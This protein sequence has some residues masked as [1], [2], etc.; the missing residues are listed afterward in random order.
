[1]THLTKTP[2]LDEFEGLPPLEEVDIRRVFAEDSDKL[3]SVDEAVLA[4]AGTMSE[5]TALS[6]QF[7]ELATAKPF[8]VVGGTMTLM[9]TPIDCFGND[10]SPGSRPTHPESSIPWCSSG[11]CGRFCTPTCPNRGFDPKDF[12]HKV[13]RKAVIILNTPVTQ[14]QVYIRA[15]YYGIRTIVATGAWV[16]LECASELAPHLYDLLAEDATHLERAML[17]IPPGRCTC[18]EHLL[19]DCT[20]DFQIA[21]RGVPATTRVQFMTRLCAAGRCS[22]SAGNVCDALREIAQNR[23]DVDHVRLAGLFV[24]QRTHLEARGLLLTDV[25]AYAQDQIA[26][27]VHFGAR[28]A[29]ASLK[30][31]AQLAVLGMLRSDSSYPELNSREFLASTW[32]SAGTCGETDWR[33][34]TGSPPID[35]QG[36][37]FLHTLPSLISGEIPLRA[38]HLKLAQTRICAE[39]DQIFEKTHNQADALSGRSVSW[40]CIPA[41][42]LLLQDLKT[43]GH[44]PRNPT[45]FNAFSGFGA[46][47]VAISTLQ[48]SKLVTLDANRGAK[49]PTEELL[50]QIEQNVKC[51][52]KHLVSS[53]EVGSLAHHG[54][55]DLTWAGP[56]YGDLE[57]YSIDGGQAPTDYPNPKAFQNFIRRMANQLASLTAVGGISVVDIQDVRTRSG[58]YDLTRDLYEAMTKTFELL[59]IYAKQPTHSKGTVRLI[60]VWKRRG[61]SAALKKE[62]GKKKAPYKEEKRVMFKTAN[63]THPQKYLGQRVCHEH[64]CQVCHKPYRHEHRIKTPV[65]SLKYPNK[66]DDCQRSCCIP[67]Y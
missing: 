35:S 39:L 57:K 6:K 62:F 29:T 59:R 15:R 1:M 56:P 63:N 26:L 64:V 27:N 61:T 52:V 65:E 51:E 30:S 10:L 46:D 14:E 50:R 49:E 40:G 32:I 18:G 36:N 5:E 4:S 60:H 24:R 28:S 53:F 58:K 47:A 37:L 48:P 25:G 54:K 8:Q 16:L 55:F 7:C 11:P 33:A 9:E 42:V 13:V 12:D 2:L 38:L 22:G 3:N 20:G 43:W 23:V 34:L 45:V 41:F 19:D 44:L 66:C 21:S 17:S 31:V 67:P